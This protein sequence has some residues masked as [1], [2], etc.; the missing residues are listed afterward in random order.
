MTTTI[1][2]KL[3]QELKLGVNE[4]NHPFRFFTLATCDENNVPQARTVVLRDVNEDG[5]I[6]FYTDKRSQKVTQLQNN[7]KVSLLFYHPEKLL[8]LKING[9]AAFET[10]TAVLET[11][12]TSLY[13][14]SKNDYTTLKPPGSSISNATQVEYLTVENYFC[15]ITIAPTTIEYL[16]LKRPNHLR[17]RF[18]KKNQ[19]EWEGTFL[20][21]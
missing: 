16:R 15:K 2:K 13:E 19:E 14:K 5:S 3:I 4:K 21:P 1:F 7:P 6:S 8:Q 12:F 9:E 11:T 18:N 20:V 10:N 17:V